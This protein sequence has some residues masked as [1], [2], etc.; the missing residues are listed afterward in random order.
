MRMRRTSSRFSPAA[1]LSRAARANSTVARCQRSWLSA[2]TTETFLRRSRSLSERSVRRLSLRLELKGSS[3][4]NLTVQ[5]KK[6][7]T[8]QLSRHL[9]DLEELQG[10]SLLYVVE[11]LDADAAFEALAHRADVIFKA[12]QGGDVALVDHDSVP[13]H[14]D[15]VVA[16]NLATGHIASGNRTDG[17]DPE[18]RA[19]LS[20]T[21]LALLGLGGEHAAHG[22]LYLLERLVDHVIGPDLHTLPLGDLLGGVGRSDVEA[23]HDPAAR[24]TEHHIRVGHGPNTRAHY[25]NPHLVSGE[26]GECFLQRLHA[27]G[28][29]R[30]D[31]EVEV[32]DAAFSEQ[33]LERASRASLREL[34]SA[35]RS[36]GLV[37]LV[38]GVAFVVG[39]LE[40]RTRFGYAG[41]AQYLDRVA[42]AG[43]FDA[44]SCIVEH[45]PHAPIGGAR[46]HDVALMERAAVYKERG[47]RAASRVALA[48]DYVPRGWS[49]RIRLQV[50][51]L[52]DDQYVLE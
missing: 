17:R 6:Q 19:D 39:S 16:R 9:Y 2:S 51:E 5:N 34:L 52:R 26:P 33:L 23:Q 36:F 18:N 27:P 43:F 11:V 49:M 46:E 48:L 20:R 1:G 29:V 3:S 14:P 4:S 7:A 35:K 31:D 24:R 25:V 32:L 10:V 28:N 40:P 30:L 22:G 12:P 45:R 47:D 15:T 41:E 8:V 21:R 13:H 42:W 38:A 44:L 37:G 50:L